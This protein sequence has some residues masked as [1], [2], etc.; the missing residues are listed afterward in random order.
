MIPSTPYRATRRAVAASSTVQ[1]K[2]SK[3][4]PCGPSNPWTAETY[5][6]ESEPYDGLIWSVKPA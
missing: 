1:V 5:A 6:V 3:G 2:T 4:A